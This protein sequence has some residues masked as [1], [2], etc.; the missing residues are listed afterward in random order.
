M[1][2]GI[3]MSHETV[4]KAFDPFFTTKSEGLGGIGLPMVETFVRGAGGDIFIESTLGFGTTVSLHLP[5]AGLEI[6]SV[7]AAVSSRG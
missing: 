5:A 7:L 2:T 1:D 6:D 4:A 3:G